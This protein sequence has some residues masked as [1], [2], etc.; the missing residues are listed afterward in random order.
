MACITL[1]TALAEH[2]SGDPMTAMKMVAIAII[3]A[4]AGLKLRHILPVT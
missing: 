4:L 3:A 1:L 2:H